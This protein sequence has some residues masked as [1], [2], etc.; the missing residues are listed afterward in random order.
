[1]L[2]RISFE[3]RLT[4]LVPWTDD[5]VDFYSHVETVRS[6]IEASEV[7]AEVRAVTNRAESSLTIDFT[8]EATQHQLAEERALGIVRSAIESGGARHFGM[9]PLGPS[10]TASAG[11]H[12]GM[13]T[14]VW[15]RRRIL[16]GVAA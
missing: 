12:S 16:V 7:I 2:Y 8:I 6:K 11:A 15:H 5:G 14:P 1:M 3:F 13:E 9:S 4:R 10:L